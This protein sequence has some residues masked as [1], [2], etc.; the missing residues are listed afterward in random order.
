M[1]IIDSV[2]SK[3]GNYGLIC[4]GENDGK[5]EAKAVVLYEP[6]ERIEINIEH[7]IYVLRPMGDCIKYRGAIITPDL[8][9]TVVKFDI[10]LKFYNRYWQISLPT[11]YDYADSSDNDNNDDQK[12]DTQRHRYGLSNAGG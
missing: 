12:E 6:Q 2:F 1:T 10:L 7:W 8:G 9:Q 11:N 3:C 5:F 4:C